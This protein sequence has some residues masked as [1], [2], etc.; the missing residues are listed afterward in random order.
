MRKY[1][2]CKRIVNHRILVT[3][4]SM[5]RDCKVCSQYAVLYRNQ[6]L[7]TK[8]R[9]KVAVKSGK[10]FLKEKFKVKIVIQ[11][12]WKKNKWLFLMG[13]KIKILKP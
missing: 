11:S 5:S 7:P 8:E 3:E 9:I 6:P 1:M 10:R 13:F 12:H 4:T 2:N